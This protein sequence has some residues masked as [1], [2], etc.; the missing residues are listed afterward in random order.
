M[1]YNSTCMGNI[2]EMLAASRGFSRS[3]YW[4]MSN[5]FY[6]DRPLCHGNE[7][8]DKIDHNSACVRY[9]SKIFSSN[10]GFSWTLS[11]Y[12]SQILQ[13]LTL[14]AITRKFD[15]KWAITQLVYEILPRCLRLLW[16]FRGRAIEWCQTN[17]AT[18]DP[19]TMATKFEIW[20]N[21]SLKY[22]I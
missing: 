1:C 14:V 11:N 19:V 5:K 18:I 16:G 4:I 9:V 20:G 10:T 8:W 21:K 15:T 3:S 13:R 12:A 17:S 22:E 7:I 2:A 6:H